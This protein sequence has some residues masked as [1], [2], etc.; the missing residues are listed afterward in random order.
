MKSLT[1]AVLALL[2]GADAARA[3]SGPLTATLR[4]GEPKDFAFR[5]GPFLVSPNLQLPEIGY[6]SN[7]FDEDADPKHDWTITL[8]PDINLFARSGVI[9]FVGVAANDL[10][11]YTKYESERSISRDFRGRLDATFSRVRP[12]V[13][14][15]HMD[16]KDRANREIDARARRVNREVSGGVAFDL[17]AIANIYVMAAQ[18]EEDYRET[19]TFKGVRLAENL[20][21]RT[22]QFG[23]GVKL[24]MTPF[25]S[26]RMSADVAQDSFANL[27]IRN[28]KS[29]TAAVNVEFAPEAIIKGTASVGYRE[30]EPESP[31]VPAFHGVVSAATLSSTLLGRATIVASAERSVRYSF[32]TSRGYYVESGADL[33]YTQQ[34]VGHFD[35]QLTGSRRWL[36]YTRTTP[37]LRPVVDAYGG[38]VGYRFHDTSRIGFNV[39]S[40]ERLD[41]VRPDR[42]YSRR[43]FFGSYTYE[44]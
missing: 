25:T 16:V 15:A 44:R 31:L 10:T 4:L 17:S 41:E 28:A 9:Q 22:E 2:T 23:G 27:P 18:V 13:A 29:R 36:D 39:E 19:E 8:K 6:D 42:T 40:S 14:A 1:I 34:L 20:N 24:Q 26:I 12:W 5:I 7:V 35:V 43:R 21:R 38:G 32:E 37:G 11:Y 30:F 3:Q 33:V